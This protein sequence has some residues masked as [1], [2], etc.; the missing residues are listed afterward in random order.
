MPKKGNVKKNI[1]KKVNGGGGNTKPYTL[2]LQNEQISIYEC[3]DLFDDFYSY[4]DIIPSTQVSKSI[5]SFSTLNLLSPPY[6]TLT[7]KFQNEV[8]F[9][10][11]LYSKND[12]RFNYV[13]G[14]SVVRGEKQHEY[15]FFFT[16]PMTVMKFQDIRKFIKMG[17]MYITHL[18]DYKYSVQVTLSKKY[19]NDNIISFLEKLKDLKRYN[20]WIA[21]GNNFNYRTK[22]GYL[23]DNSLD[24][25]TN[26]KIIIE[27]IIKDVLELIEKNIEK[28]NNINDIKE[29]LGKDI[30]Y[31]DDFLYKKILEFLRSIEEE[32][33][34]T[35]E[36]EITSSSSKKYAISNSKHDKT[37][38]L[39]DSN[40]YEKLY[41]LAEKKQNI[42]S[43]NNY[44]IYFPETLLF[45][46]VINNEEN[47]NLLQKN[48][49]NIVIDFENR[50]LSDI[51]VKYEKLEVEYKELKVEY[52][53]L[54]VE[55]EKLQK[56][57]EEEEEGEGEGEKKKKEREITELKELILW[58]NNDEIINLI[59]QNHDYQEILTALKNIEK[60]IKQQGGKKH[61]KREVLGKT[62]VIYKIQGDRKEYV[63]HKGKLTTVK[64]Y[65]ALMKQKAKPKKM[66][67]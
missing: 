60:N 67:T 36:I 4:F 23:I 22:S 8:Y 33:Y 47:F 3:K 54:K 16:E 20:H 12:I 24:D 38:K 13:K 45:T 7:A 58:I 18:L 66:S 5:F 31:M 30:I 57:R 55:Y 43:E 11:E 61:S 15:H 32:Y 44:V 41:T 6:I 52:E 59:I 1:S 10:I 39:Y 48:K 63:K 27:V 17:T 37:K 56:K 62:M 29:N 64:D 14:K 19:N 49:N 21:Q 42:L 2:E 53:K 25:K 51:E 28:I 50:L 26:K 46:L 35:G 9:Y 34:V 65:K 40:I